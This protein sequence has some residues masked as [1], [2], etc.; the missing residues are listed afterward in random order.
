VLSITPRIIRQT[1]LMK[2]RQAADT[3]TG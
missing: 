1:T 3:L 2:T